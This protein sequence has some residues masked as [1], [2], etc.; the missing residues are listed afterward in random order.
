[1]LFGTVLRVT[2]FPRQNGV[3]LKEEDEKWVA[4]N[5][6]SGQLEDKSR[7]GRTP[8]ADAAAVQHIHSSQNAAL[9][10]I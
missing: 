5:E 6:Q 10:Q 4:R 8:K 2:V 3:A 1:M 9:L 7:S